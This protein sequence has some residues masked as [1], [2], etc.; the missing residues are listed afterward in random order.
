MNA[1]SLIAASAPSDLW[2]KLIYAFQGA[3]GNFGWT[4]LFVTLF[5]KLI[6]TP[7]DFCVKYS[8][9]KQTLVQKKL[10]PQIAKLKKKFG[11]N[12]DQIRI[13]TQ[14]LYKREGFKAGASCLIMAVNML[15]TMLV[16]ITFYSSI[17]KVAAY[18]MINQYE[19]LEQT[20]TNEY[21]SSLREK[22]GDETIIDEATANAWIQAN[23]ANPEDEHYQDN[24][25]YVLDSTR[26]AE[27]AM[28]NC[29]NEK[30]ESWL[31]IQNIWVADAPT[32]PLPEYDKLVS[33]S[34]SGNYDEY[35]KANIDKDAYTKIASSI[36]THSSRPQNGFLIV[37]ISVGLLSFLSQWIADLHTKL[38]NKKAQQLAKAAD[39]SEKTMKIMK[40]ILPLIWVGFAF[41]SSACFGLYLI[42]SSIA[43]I[44]FGEIIAIIVNKLTKNK[45]KEV[46]EVLEKEANRLIK[47]GKL[48]EK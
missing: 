41:S 6:M 33:S 38:H 40:I 29:W 1:L 16:F 3:F 14:A 44:T 32:A 13:Q 39:P 23:L 46:E 24:A 36:T 7:L 42:A 9:K 48:Q 5:V 15:A 43:S 20:Y 34:S 8:N 47:K 22:T 4:I 21:V 27:A 37:A 19:T 30:K 10:S 2:S 26:E 35:I 11:A 12:Q 25:S 28:L 18:E 17:R 45:Q 31:W